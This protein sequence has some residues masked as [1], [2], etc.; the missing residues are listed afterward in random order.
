M[1]KARG[2]PNT[3]SNNVTKPLRLLLLFCCLSAGA[4]ADPVTLPARAV[5]YRPELH[6][7]ARVEA[8]A[9]LTLR[10][11]LA[12]RVLKLAAMPGQKVRA[13]ESLV[14]LGGPRLAGARAAA[15]ARVAAATQELVAARQ[16]AASVARTYPALAN[17]QALAATQSTV[18]AARGRL[19]EAL[20][21]QRALGAQAILTSPLP[22]VVAKVESASG[23]DLPAGAPLLTLLPQAQL[24]LKA[25]LF[26]AAPPMGSAARFIPTDGAETTVHLAGELPARAA[27]GA[28]VLNFTLPSDPQWQAGQTG[29]LIIREAPKSAV[30][31]P[32]GA[33][34]LDAGH[35]YVLT[36]RAGKLLPQAVAPGPARGD[37]VLILHGLAPGTPVVVRQAYALYHRDFAAHYTPPD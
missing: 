9:P 27:N 4:H 11:P 33:L 5:S 10:T 30:A 2:F 14:W 32:A 34:I 13:G 20:A 3:E 16:N 36:E 23:V 18:A 1:R 12:G 21:A 24:W 28:R 31:V 29:R 25:E 8:A 7:W 17:R 26:G 6:G 15:R 37:D 22:A 35:W 19:A